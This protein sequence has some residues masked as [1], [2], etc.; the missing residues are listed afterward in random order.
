MLH[1]ELED[2]ALE[3]IDRTLQL[4]DP[5]LQVF[6]RR[7]LGSASRI[8]PTNF[9]AEDVFGMHESGAEK[10]KSEKCDHGCVHRP[11]SYRPK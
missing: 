6:V 5:L 11:E 2:F 3:L 9:D 7:A 10:G 4:P 8:F 1:G